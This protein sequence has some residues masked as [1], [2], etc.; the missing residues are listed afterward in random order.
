MV[1]KNRENNK[2]NQTFVGIKEFRRDITKYVTQARTN[3]AQV[4]V[5]SRN[6]PL[7][8]V[9]PL[10]DDVYTEGVLAAVKEAEADIAAG[11]VYTL[12]EAK[13]ELDL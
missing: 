1:N 3:T 4:I 7:F 9:A 6:K 11:R 12:A 8:M 2:T 10:A 13:A 5:T